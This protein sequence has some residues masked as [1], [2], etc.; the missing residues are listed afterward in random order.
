MKEAK[1]DSDFKPA[2]RDQSSIFAPL[3]RRCLAYF[4][5]TAP[6]WLL[7]DH[8]TLLGLTAMFLAGASYVMAVYWPPA[9]LLVNLWLA[10]NWY[11]DSLD[12]TLARYRNKQRPRYGFYV[13][14]V[15]DAFG[16]LF[17]FSGLALSGLISP[18]IAVF[19][20]IAYLLLMIDSFLATYT[21]GLFRVSVFKFSPTELRILLA[22]GN[23]YAFFRPVTRLS[24]ASYHFFDVA[25]TVGIALMGLFLLAS[26]ARNTLTL[27]RAEKV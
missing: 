18:L 7:P 23:T 11:G 4:A 3:E 6:A 20:L 10:V 16:S 12:G 15:V 14:H 2:Q 24:G 25:C 5:R 22:V 9:L 19:S 13:D 8:L 1:L 21:I 26:V 17:L 27:Y